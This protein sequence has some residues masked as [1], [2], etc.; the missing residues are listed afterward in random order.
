MGNTKHIPV[1]IYDNEVF[2]ARVEEGNALHRKIDNSISFDVIRPVSAEQLSYLRDM[3]ER[4]DEY[5]E[6]WKDAVRADATE[7]SL[8]D[9]LEQV[10]DEEFDEDDEESFPGKDDSDTQYLT[11]ELREQADAF[12]LENEGIEVGTWEASG[13]YE[14]AAG[15]RH[16]EYHGWDFV[17]DTDE[18]RR[19]AALYDKE[20]K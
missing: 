10:W 15:W 18:A 9:W 14:P 12:L 1:G 17:F 13:S 6:L 3:D 5:K 19:I 4:R 11:D 16:E 20:R 7:E 8:D 2:I